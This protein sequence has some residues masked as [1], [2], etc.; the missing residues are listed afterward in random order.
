MGGYPPSLFWEAS[1]AKNCPKIAFFEKIIAQKRCKYRCFCFLWLVAMEDA[2]FE[3]VFSK[4][5]FK[6]TVKYSISDMWSCQS[7]ANSGVFATCVFLGVA[8]TL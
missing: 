7:V 2:I 8:K 6:N 4:R 1:E 5:W 3:S